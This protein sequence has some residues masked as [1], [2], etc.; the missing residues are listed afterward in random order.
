MV[1]AVIQI[2]NTDNKLTQGEWA[3]FAEYM[4]GAISE[5]VYRVHF[6]GGSDWDAPWQNACWVCEVRENQIDPLTAAVKACREQWK[7]DS[8][9]I[10]WGNTVDV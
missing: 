7:Q 1:T 3:H 2:G 5:N 6:S 9:A 10:T 4:R 8:A